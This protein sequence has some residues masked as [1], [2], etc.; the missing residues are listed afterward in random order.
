VSIPAILTIITNPV[1]VWWFYREED[2][3]WFVFLL[4]VHFRIH[5]Q[6]LSESKKL[7][8]G[9]FQIWLLWLVDEFAS[10]CSSQGFVYLFLI[11]NCFRPIEIYKFRCFRLASNVP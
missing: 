4:M 2:E 9:M 6:M 5:V 1:G 7:V 11:Y 10:C 8:W 3:L